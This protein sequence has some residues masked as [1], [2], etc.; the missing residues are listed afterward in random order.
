MPCLYSSWRKESGGGGGGCLL[1]L[2]RGD[3]RCGWH[4]LVKAYTGLLLASL[5]ISPTPQISSLAKAENRRRMVVAPSNFFPFMWS[6][7]PCIDSCS[8]LQLF[9]CKN[10]GVLVAGEDTARCT[11]NRHVIVMS[12]VVAHQER[13]RREEPHRFTR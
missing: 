2:P 11:E 10:V 13:G 12:I 6:V 9:S 4:T 1:F 7:L 3:L 8:G 5:M